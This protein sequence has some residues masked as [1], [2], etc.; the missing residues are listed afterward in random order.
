MSLRR[1]KPIPACRIPGSF[2]SSFLVKRYD[3]SAGLTKIPFA[4]MQ[5]VIG[6][7]I[8]DT[9]V[10]VDLD[11]MFYFNGIGY[12][13][14]QICTN[15][16][17]ILGTEPYSS[18]MTNSYSPGLI[19]TTISDIGALICPWFGDLITVQSAVATWGPLGGVY[20]KKDHGSEGVR[21]VIRWVTN[22]YFNI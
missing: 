22:S 14:I 6:Q 2:N 3:K 7:G 10:I 5:R 8:D 17:I 19:K 21:G 15:G 1:Q 9:A 16:W 4:K 20:Y 12:D 18:F 11:F 13:K